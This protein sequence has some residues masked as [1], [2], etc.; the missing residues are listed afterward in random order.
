MVRRVE[1][2]AENVALD[3]QALNITSICGPSSR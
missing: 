2:G 3:M 1:V